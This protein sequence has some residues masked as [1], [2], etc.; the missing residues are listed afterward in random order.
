[1]RES[2]DQEES[3]DPGPES[4]REDTKKP[5]NDQASPLQRIGIKNKVHVMKIMS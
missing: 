5:M 2:L 1:M 4:M 3:T